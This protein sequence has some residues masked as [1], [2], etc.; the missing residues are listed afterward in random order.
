MENMKANIQLV[1]NYIKEYSL[2]LKKRIV[3]NTKIQLGVSITFEVVNIREEEDNKVAQ[4]NMEYN[5]D[6]IEDEKSNIGKIHLV[7]QA[8]FIAEKN[9]AN[10]KIEEKLKYEGA[11]LL[12]QLI[13]SYIMANTALSDIQIIKLPLID[14]KK[15]FKV[16]KKEK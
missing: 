16:A 12:A 9:L 8:L 13:S 5:L 4:V 7:M 14:F 15:F 2:N 10:E 11:P 3:E 1:D 6:L